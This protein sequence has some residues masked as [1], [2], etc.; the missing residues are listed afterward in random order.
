VWYGLFQL[1]EDYT[2]IHE[3]HLY[4]GNHIFFDIK[5]YKNGS[6]V[7]YDTITQEVFTKFGVYDPHSF[8]L[9]FTAYPDGKVEFKLMIDEE[10]IV[11][12]NYI[13]LY[14]ANIV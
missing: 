7:F 8:T 2:I 1:G 14:G 3:I 5:A 10:T 9:E 11:S 13:S 12:M 6:I 4:N